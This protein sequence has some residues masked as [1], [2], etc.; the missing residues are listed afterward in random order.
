MKFK[1]D[2]YLIVSAT[3]LFV[4][5]LVSWTDQKLMDRFQRNLLE[6]Y[7]VKCLC[8]FRSGDESRIFFP[9]SLLCE[10]LY[11]FTDFNFIS[12]LMKKIWPV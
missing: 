7:D 8:R 12:V 9:L 3:C 4:C 6:G 1:W 5:P 2:I 11:I 10:G